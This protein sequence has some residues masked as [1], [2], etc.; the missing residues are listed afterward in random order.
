[1]RGR[2]SVALKDEQDEVAPAVIVCG[3]RIEDGGDQGP[4]VLDSGGLRMEVGNDGGLVRS[5]AVDGAIV[6]RG[7]LTKALAALALRSKSST[8]RRSFSRAS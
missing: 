5:V 2:F 1:M 4:D 6:R 8:A 7:E 3:G